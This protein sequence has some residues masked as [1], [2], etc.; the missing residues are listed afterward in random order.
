MAQDATK[1]EKS[2]QEIVDS[3]INTQNVTNRLKLIGKD[4]PRL[5]KMIRV[6]LNNEILIEKGL[7]VDNNKEFQSEMSKIYPHQIISPW[8]RIN[9]I[10]LAIKYCLEKIDILQSDSSSTKQIQEIITNIQ[11]RCES[12]KSIHAENKQDTAKND[13]QSVIVNMTE[14]LATILASSMD[15][16]DNDKNVKIQMNCFSQILSC[17]TQSLV[18]FS[19]PSIIENYCQNDKNEANWKFMGKDVRSFDGWN[20]EIK[21]SKITNIPKD[22]N[23]N[24]IDKNNYN[25]ELSMVDI[26]HHRQAKIFEVRKQGEIIN[27]SQNSGNQW[28]AFAFDWDLEMRLV[29]SQSKLKCTNASL[30]ILKD[31]KDAIHFD[32]DLIK[33]ANENEVKMYQK[34]VGNKFVSSKINDNFKV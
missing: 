12:R 30:G 32:S 21:F 23:K 7:V 27:I 11:K 22:E 1:N 24:D 25:Y 6:S 31:H 34:V 8:D 13:D 16:N 20:I 14:I 3:F 18:T 15:D 26:I 10:I 29:Y 17:I 9:N 4:L 2:L 19:F 5:A 28:M 33:E